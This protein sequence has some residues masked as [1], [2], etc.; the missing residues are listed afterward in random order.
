MAPEAKLCVAVLG[1]ATVPPTDSCQINLGQI[2]ASYNISHSLLQLIFVLQRF[3]VVVTTNIWFSHCYNLFALL[4]GLCVVTILLQRIHVV[5]I[6][7]R[8]IACNC[9]N[10][11][12]KPCNNGIFWLLQAFQTP[13]A[14]QPDQVFSNL[15]L[16]IGWQMRRCVQKFRYWIMPQ[17]TKRN[18]RANT[19]GTLFFICLILPAGLNE[20]WEW[21]GRESHIV[22]PWRH[23][24]P[25]R[26]KYPMKEPLIKLMLH[27]PSVIRIPYGTTSNQLKYPVTNCFLECI[28]LS[29]FDYAFF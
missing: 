19:L 22:P 21:V 2:F 18:E 29:Q 15:F 28:Y 5:T 13:L 24:P 16:S 20:V 14:T 6:L 4:Q 9:Y 27:T 3:S 25:S 7:I 26:L 10:L 8:H 23:C 17:I 12:D 1:E 11:F